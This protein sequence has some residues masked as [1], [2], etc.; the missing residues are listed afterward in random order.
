MRFYYQDDNRR[1]STKCIR[2]A[3]S[4]T[5]VDV[6]LSLIEKFRPDL[7]MLSHSQYGLYEVHASGGMT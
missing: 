1:V 3:S 2:V 4:A 6:I 7:R 5:T